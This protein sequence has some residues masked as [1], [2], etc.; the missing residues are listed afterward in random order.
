MLKGIIKSYITEYDETLVRMAHVNEV[1]AQLTTD[2]VFVTDEELNTDEDLINY[3]GS[4][5]QTLFNR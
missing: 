5:L 3:Q 4:I 1:F 2:L